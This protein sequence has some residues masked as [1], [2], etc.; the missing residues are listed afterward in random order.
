MSR[1]ISKNFIDGPIAPE[2]IGEAIAKHKSK[3]GIGAHEIFLGQVRE[4]DFEGQKVTEL[5]YTA[6]QEMAEKTLQQ[7]KDEA[8]E[9]HD[10]TC[11]HIYHSL[12]KVGIGEVSLFVMVSAA[13]RQA[14]FDALHEVVEAIKARVPIWKKE[15]FA[16]NQAQWKENSSSV[17]YQQ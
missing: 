5:E 12:G 14:C 16:D 9:K 1:K 3:T 6:Y 2:F 8:F 10:L 13:H 4:D 17:H 15:L 11:M 7:I